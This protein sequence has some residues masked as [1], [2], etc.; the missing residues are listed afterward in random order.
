MVSGIYGIDPGVGDSP[1]NIFRLNNDLSGIEVIY[2]FSGASKPQGK[3]LDGLDGYLYGVTRSGGQD[4]G[5]VIYRI[6]PDGSEFTIFHHFINSTG[7]GPVVGLVSSEDGWLYGATRIGGQ[8]GRGVIFRI[9]R[10]GSLY[11]VLL[12]LNSAGG[13]FPDVPLKMDEHDYVYGAAQGAGFF[14]VDGNGDF[15]SLRPL[16]MP[17][18]INLLAQAF[19]PEVSVV[20]PADQSSSVLHDDIFTVSSISGAS[21]YYLELSESPI[22]SGSPFVFESTSSSITVH[23]L[24]PSTTYFARVR[25]GLYPFYGNV[26]S[27]TTGA[28]AAAVPEGV[29]L[30]AADAEVNVNV[31]GAYPNPSNYAFNLSPLK[32]ETDKIISVIV[33]NA[34]GTIVYENKNVDVVTTLQF[35]HDLPRGVYFLKT[36]TQKDVRTS[37]L[38]KN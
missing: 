27:F 13:R 38:V 1:G 30:R 29:R 7:R 19:I 22:F 31:D 21:N 33:T 8:S 34:N 12:H 18:N 15:V 28:S 23:G 10:D 25:T 3:L 20:T 37:R 5:G 4:N 24:Q 36:K 26:T 2:T 6:K 14:K 32:T 16:N 17:E 11:Q 9:A 35:G